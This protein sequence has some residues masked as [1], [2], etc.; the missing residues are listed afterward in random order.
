[1]KT[2]EK[3][4]QKPGFCLFQPAFVYALQS[5]HF[6]FLSLSA[7][8]V[9]AIWYMRHRLHAYLLLV[10]GVR[11]SNFENKEAMSENTSYK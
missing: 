8:V 1:M 3:R 11:S 10:F 2:K 7:N 5:H 9:A 4:R 6:L